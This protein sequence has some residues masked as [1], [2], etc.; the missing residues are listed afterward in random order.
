MWKHLHKCTTCFMRLAY[1]DVN[2]N[3]L[4]RIPLKFNRVEEFQILHDVPQAVRKGNVDFQNSLSWT[5]LPP[6][7]KLFPLHVLQTSLVEANPNDAFENR[8]SEC[9]QV[10]QFLE[11][12]FVRLTLIQIGQRLFVNLGGNGRCCSQHILKP[13]YIYVNGDSSEKNDWIS[14]CSLPRR[15]LCLTFPAAEIS[16]GFDLLQALSAAWLH[17]CLAPEN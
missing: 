10:A 1:L 6:S 8:A 13:N 9:R 16:R 5:R 7:S 15:Q 2:T 3:F 14:T 4:C 12:D 17:S 11:L